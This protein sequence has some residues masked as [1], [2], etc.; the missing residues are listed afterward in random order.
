MN[1]I[2][3]VTVLIVSCHVSAIFLTQGLEIV[4]N[5]ILPD[6]VDI[7]LLDL[8]T[9]KVSQIAFKDFGFYYNSPTTVQAQYPIQGIIIQPNGRALVEIIVMH[10]KTSIRTVAIVDTSCPYTYFAGDT[11]RALNIVDTDH[12]NL[13]VHGQPITVY[14]SFNHFSDVNVLGSS[15]FVENKVEIKLNYFTVKL[16]IT[17]HSGLS[18]E[19]LQEL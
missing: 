9:S 5:V 16:Y 3:L 2:I 15:F 1:L 13:I 17:K 6:I 11:L 10:K 14:K 8:N 7:M 19:E 4:D 18:I 12:A